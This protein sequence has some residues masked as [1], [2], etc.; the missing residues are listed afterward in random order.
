MQPT[1]VGQDDVPNAPPPRGEVRGLKTGSQIRLGGAA[2]C[3]GA[4]LAII[5]N[6]LILGADPV[7]A[8]DVVSYPL[9]ANA[10]RLGQVFFAL[11]QALMAAGIVALVG[12][13]MAGAGWRARYGGGLAVLGFVVTI[14]GE[15]VLA[16]VATQAIDSNAANAASS[17]FG[18]GMLLADIGLILF[19]LDALRAGTWPRPW[20]TLPTTLGM[21][22]LLVVTPVVLS[23]GFASVGA[24]VVIT[25]QDLLIGAIGL[26]LWRGRTHDAPVADSQ[27]P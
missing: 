25:L 21:F 6:A 11:T 3:V 16:F 20:S 1:D 10:F 24:F 9:S 22:Q 26:R 15:L 7:V 19:G 12:S 4:A 18:I 14:P 27:A 2:A 8:S 23:A 5:G 17:V 13:R